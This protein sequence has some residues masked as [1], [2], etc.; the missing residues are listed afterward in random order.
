MKAK[1]IAKLGLIFCVFCALIFTI[2]AVSSKTVLKVLY[3]VK[4][5]VLVEKYSTEYGIDKR[6]LFAV[7]KTESS[8]DP[9]SVSSA[10]AE[11]LTQ[12]TPETF[13]WLRLKTGETEGE[14]SLFDE[15][16]SIKYGAYFLSLLLSEFDN[17]ETAV[18]AY[19]AGRG[20]VNGWL[21]DTDISPDGKTLTNIP[22][23]ETAHYLKKV[24]RAIDIY[25]RLYDF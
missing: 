3:P 24:T 23:P 13:E 15:E 25:T 14:M 5:S 22:V 11:G 7:I 19:H 18:A 9:H 16:T 6:L 17:T 2:T 20:R 4:Y 1:G 12:I 10:G 8:F 21:K